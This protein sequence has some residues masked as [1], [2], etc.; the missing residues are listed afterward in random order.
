MLRADGHPYGT[1]PDQLARDMQPQEQHAWPGSALVGA[2]PGENG[3][4]MHFLSRAVYPVRARRDS[5][6]EA[7]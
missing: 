3:L 4:V 7:R 5:L 1:I 6:A 2:G